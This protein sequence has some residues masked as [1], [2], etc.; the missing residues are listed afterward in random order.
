M[1]GQAKGRE[2][3]AAFRADSTR[4]FNAASL[5]RSRCAGRGRSMEELLKT[6]DIVMISFLEATLREAGIPS[7]VFDAGMNVVE[8][9]I[10]AFPRRLMVHGDD[11]ERARRLVMDAGCGHA[12]PKPRRA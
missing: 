11:L 1:A 5:S 7:L 6:Q 10:V 12:L 3:A 9:G 8:G 4:P 2:R